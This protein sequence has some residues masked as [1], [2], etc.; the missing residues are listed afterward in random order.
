MGGG[1][2]GQRPLKMDSFADSVLGG[3]AH[4]DVDAVIFEDALDDVEGG[5]VGVALAGEVGEV[6]MF[7]FGV[8][9]FAEEVT[10]GISN[11]Y[12]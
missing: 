2:R 11:T 10:A 1:L 3:D 12:C 5:V 9:D 4:V 8:S 6:D 7:K